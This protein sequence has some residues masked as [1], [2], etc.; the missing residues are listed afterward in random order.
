MSPNLIPTLFTTGFL[1]SALSS[2]VTGS[3]A[4][5]FGRRLACLSFCLIYALSCILT[6]IPSLPCLLTGRVLGGVGTSLLFSVFESWMVA[7]FR[8]RYLES[9]GLDLGRTFGVM[10]TVNSVVAIGSG[11]VSEWSVGISGTR[12]APFGVCVVVLGIA[13]LFIY[14]QWVRTSPLSLSYP[15]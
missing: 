5:R 10:S 12:K 4:D 7:D 2:I 9:K 11:V 3:L 14:T 13:A 1:S 8:A 15:A 6:T